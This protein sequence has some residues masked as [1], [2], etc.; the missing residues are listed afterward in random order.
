MSDRISFNQ[1]FVQSS[2]CPCLANLLLKL[3]AFREA[4]TWQSR[5]RWYDHSQEDK[6]VPIVK[7]P[8]ATR[9]D[10]IR[11]LLF[12][13]VENRTERVCP[14]R[15]PCAIS[16]IHTT[17]LLLSMLEVVYG[18][19]SAAPFHLAA[20]LGTFLLCALARYY[21]QLRRYSYPATVWPIVPLIGDAF[22]FLY[23]PFSYFRRCRYVYSG[24]F[25]RSLTSRMKL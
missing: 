17:P 12:K 22:Q 6:H 10:L 19:W 4:S 15:S 2:H 24:S 20:A 11:K 25:Y 3:H 1:R 5:S 16:Q 13:H 14:P 9:G 8:T 21:Y 7:P 18:R 23:T